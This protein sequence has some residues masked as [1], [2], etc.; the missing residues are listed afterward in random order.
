MLQLVVTCLAMFW[1]TLLVRKGARA[2][3]RARGR[4][5]ARARPGLG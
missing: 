1:Y 5:S 2:R 3:A 4:A